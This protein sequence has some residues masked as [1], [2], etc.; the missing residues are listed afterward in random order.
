MKKSNAKEFIKKAI[1]KHGLRY[2]YL[3]VDYK[4]SA[5]KIV[6]GCPVHGDFEQSPNKHLCGHNCPKCYDRSTGGAKTKTASEFAIEASI[7]HNNFYDYSN[8]VYKNAF[9]KVKIICPIH[10][11]FL[12]TPHGHLDGKGCWKCSAKK[13]KKENEWIESLKIETIIKHHKVKLDLKHGAYIFDGYDPKTNIVYE[14]LGDYWHGNPKRFKQELFNTKCDRT[15]GELFEE[16]VDKFEKIISY[17]YDIIF[18]WEWDFLY[19]G[20]HKL[21]TKGKN[22]EDIIFSLLN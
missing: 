8:V 1:L 18:I 21:L 12:Q 5:T 10:G 6:I 16:T 20:V 9:T 22:R 17:G 3:K 14:F 4:N 2:S 7:K 15:F 11:E 19:N 13:S